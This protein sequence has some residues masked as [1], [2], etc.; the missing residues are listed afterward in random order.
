MTCINYI[1]N[2]L[3]KFVIH[4]FLFLYEK[5]KRQKNKV[6]MERAKCLVRIKMMTIQKMGYF[7]VL[8]FYYPLLLCANV[9][10]FIWR[11]REKIAQSALTSVNAHGNEKQTK[12]FASWTNLSQTIRKGMKRNRE[13]SDW[14]CEWATNTINF[15]I[16]NSPALTFIHIRKQTNGKK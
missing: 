7:S 16:E 11:I 13:S 9:K 1:W 10:V 6:P 4:L 12:V 5:C 8:L 2:W 15:T 3:W 14:F